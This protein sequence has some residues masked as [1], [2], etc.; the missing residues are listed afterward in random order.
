M[1]T[2]LFLV[3]NG[4]EMEQKDYISLAELGKILGISRIA[5][6]KKVKKGEIKAIKIGRAYAVPITEV[7]FLNGQALSEDNKKEINAAVKKVVDEY[8]E[9]LKKLGNE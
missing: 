2:K 5:V 3:N 9:L 4:V 8:G 1:L 6:F 7:P